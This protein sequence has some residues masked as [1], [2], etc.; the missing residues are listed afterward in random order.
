MDVGAGGPSGRGAAAG[1]ATRTPTRIDR[2]D[3]RD[4]RDR[5]VLVGSAVLTAAEADRECPARSREET[6]EM[7]DEGDEQE[8]RIGGRRPYGEQARRARLAGHGAFQIVGLDSA[9]FPAR[10]RRPPRQ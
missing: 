4:L 2:L 3:G 9:R 8:L 5:S 7:I 6:R 1:G 10:R